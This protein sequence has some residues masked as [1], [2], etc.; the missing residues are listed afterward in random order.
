MAK[1]GAFISYARKDGEA[2][3]N[4]LRERLQ[5]EAPDLRIWQDHRGIEGG[6]G[7]WRQIEEALENVEFLIIVMTDALLRS[8]ITGKEWRYAR[9]QGVCV[10]QVKG[11]GFDFTNPRLTRW[12]K[13]AQIYDLDD[14]RARGR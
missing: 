2:F 3:A 1:S 6:V 8:E 11:P 9:Q 4:S 5:S 7:W 13:K 10:Y 14:R 12:M